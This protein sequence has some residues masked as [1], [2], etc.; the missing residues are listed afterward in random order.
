MLQ[1]IHNHHHQQQQQ[2][3]NNNGIDIPSYLSPSKKYTNVNNY[4]KERYETPCPYLQHLNNNSNAN[5]YK[6]QSNKK[7]NI[8]SDKKPKKPI[9]LFLP[10]NTRRIDPNQHNR[11]PL[12]PPPPLLLLLLLLLLWILL[13]QLLILLLLLLLP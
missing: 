2:L 3:N 4:W 5:T 7:A 12:S 9:P 1:D 13:L 11:L 10:Y 6:K 8:I